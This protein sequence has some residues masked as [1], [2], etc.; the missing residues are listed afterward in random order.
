MLPFFFFPVSIYQSVLG[1]PLRGQLALSLHRSRRWRGRGN[2]NKTSLLVNSREGAA[3]V[4]SC[5]DSQQLG[6]EER[7]NVTHKQPRRQ[8]TS[9][10]RVAWLLGP[11]SLGRNG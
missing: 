3:E 2:E 8:R 1:L 6:P 10:T 7:I 4:V 5:H 9:N 11:V